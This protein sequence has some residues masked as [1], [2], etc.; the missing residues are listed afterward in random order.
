MARLIEDDTAAALQRGRL[1]QLANQ[2]FSLEVSL[3][4]FRR[5]SRAALAAGLTLEDWAIE[6]CNRA[7]L[8]AQHEGKATG[9]HG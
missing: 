6:E 2:I 1:Q 3:E 4:D 5:Y 8:T 9:T 7:A